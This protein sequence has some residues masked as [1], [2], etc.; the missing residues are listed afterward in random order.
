MGLTDYPSP[1]G[2]SIKVTRQ[3]GELIAHDDNHSQKPTLTMHAMKHFVV[4]AGM[5]VEVCLI[6][7][8]LIFAQERNVPIID[9][10]KADNA[11]HMRDLQQKLEQ[12]E[13]ELDSIKRQTNLMSPKDRIALAVRVQRLDMEIQ[14]LKKEISAL[15]VKQAN[16]QTSSPRSSTVMASNCCNMEEGKEQDGFATLVSYSCHSKQKNMSVSQATART[17]PDQG[18]PRM[19]AVIS[20]QKARQFE[21]SLAGDHDRLAHGTNTFCIRFRNP[22]SGNLADP[23]DLSVEATISTKRMNF[24]RAV[25]RI[26]RLTTGHFCARVNFPVSG[27]WLITVKYQKSQGNGRVVFEE[28]VD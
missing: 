3:R 13:Q 6:P 23:G 5:L 26:T 25:V 2:E 4:L 10:R 9:S 19:S 15:K 16:E 7:N 17:A 24:A 12:A 22:Q 20:S 8:H 21:V 1:R 28:M 14:Q 27:S 18:C 11:W